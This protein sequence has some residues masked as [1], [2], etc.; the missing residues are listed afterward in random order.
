MT[1]III[2]MTRIIGGC[3]L[4]ADILGY[5]I[6]KLQEQGVII[7]KLVFFKYRLVLYTDLLYQANLTL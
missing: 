4:V 7:F 6:N 2:Y 5:L 3:D 1:G